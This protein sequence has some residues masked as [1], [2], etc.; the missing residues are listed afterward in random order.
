MVP[1]RRWDL[2]NMKTDHQD[3]RI[4]NELL[5]G[6]KLEGG[7]KMSGRT[8]TGVDQIR[9]RQFS[10]EK[11]L[12]NVVKCLQIIT[13]GCFGGVVGW[14]GSHLKM[15]EWHWL[16]EWGLER[17]LGGS[18]LAAPDLHLQKLGLK[19]KKITSYE[20]LSQMR[21]AKLMLRFYQKYF[22]RNLHSFFGKV[23]NIF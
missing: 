4:P 13:L 11:N 20:V 17:F 19:L 1:R 3:S 6:Q 8:N 7:S 12:K 2:G 23:L 16:W 21:W 9:P 14:W 10:I 5:L 18:E 22:S 15:N